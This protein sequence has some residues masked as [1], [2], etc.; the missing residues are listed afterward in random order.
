M[1]NKAKE[2]EKENC[3]NERITAMSI[4]SDLCFV[5]PLR[6]NQFPC[7]WLLVNFICCCSHGFE[8][9]IITSSNNHQTKAKKQK[10]K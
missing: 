4:Q 5:Q 2:K 8:T 3:D 10:N 6:I 1:I 7:Q 9:K